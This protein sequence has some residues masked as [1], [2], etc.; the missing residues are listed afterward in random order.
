MIRDR[1]QVP[2][3][4]QAAFIREMQQLKQNMMPKKGTSD[5]YKA[6]YDA[7]SHIADMDP[8]AKGIDVKLMFGNEKLLNAI[9]TY[10]AGKKSV[11][12]TDDGKER[13]NNC[14]DSLAILKKHVPGGGMQEEAKK[15]VD[16]VN[17]VR[18]APEAGQ[19]NHLDLSAY[20]G[21]RAK[22]A[23]SARELKKG[24]AQPGL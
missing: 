4:N 1:Y 11:R 23:R 12:R 15:L 9:K 14:M 19:K 22:E 16:R 13:F 5:E 20:G 3:E 10:S 24:G 2:K 18:K 8:N 21:Q 7:V 17:E 6:L